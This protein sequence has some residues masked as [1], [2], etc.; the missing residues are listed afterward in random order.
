M[1]FRI[2]DE[3]AVEHG[4]STRVSIEFVAL[5]FQ[6]AAEFVEVE[7]CFQ[8]LVE[9]AEF[10]TET[11]VVLEM[12]LVHCH[13]LFFRVVRTENALVHRLQEQSRR[14]LV[15][16]EVMLGVLKGGIDGR[17]VHFFRRD[18]IVD[19]EMRF[20]RDLRDFFDRIGEADAGIFDRTIDPIGIPW[21]ARTVSFCD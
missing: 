3:V 19:R 1:R 16:V 4:G 9:E 12:R 21:L 8:A 6:V 15:V 11:D 10:D 18:A 20:R 17:L 5:D 14:D 2:F 13:E 7:F